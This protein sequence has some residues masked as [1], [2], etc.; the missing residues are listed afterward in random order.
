MKRTIRN[1]TYRS[2]PW[3]VAGLLCLALAIG[4]TVL[5]SIRTQ[6]IDD[7]GASLALTAQAIATELDLLMEERAGDFDLW[8]KTLAHQDLASPTTAAFLRHIR[9][10]YPIYAWIGVTDAT[11]RVLAAST[12]FDAPHGQYAPSQDTPSWF[13]VAQEHSELVIEPVQKA[14]ELGGRMALGFVMPLQDK[15]GAWRGALRGLIALDELAALFE[16][17]MKTFRLLG[18]SEVEVEWQW[19]TADGLVI[20]DSVLQEAGKVNLLQWH[21]PSAQKLQ[22]DHV[23]YL[24]ETHLRRNVPVI[25]GYAKTKGVQEKSAVQWG[26]LVRLDRDA[27]LK[28]IDAHLVRIGLVGGG[29][30]LPV[31]GV[32]MWS[33]TRAK[34]EWERVQAERVRAEQ[35]EAAAMRERQQIQAVVLSMREAVVTID[36][37][38]TITVVNPAA[39]GLFGYEADELVGRNVSMLMPSPHREHHDAYLRRYRETGERHIIG[40]GREV[41]GRRKDGSTFPLYLA[42]TEIAPEMGGGERQFTA[43]LRDLSQDK[44]IAALKDTENHVL[45]LL[46]LERPFREVLGTIA[47]SLHKTLPHIAVAILL[48]DE[49]ARCLRVGATAGVPLSYEK[50]LEGLPIAEDAPP[51]GIAALTGQVMDVRDIGTDPR[52]AAFREVALSHG[53]HACRSMPILDHNEQAVGV[54][55]V[56]PMTATW[57][58][59]LQWKWIDG[60]VRL[61]SLAVT[62]Y[63]TQERLDLAQRRYQTLIEDLDAV[64]WEADAQTWRFTYVSP[65][66]ERI[67]GYPLEQW[68]SE[69]EFWVHLIHPDDRERAVKTCRQAVAES[70]D[71]NFEYRTVAADGRIVWIRDIVHIAKDTDGQVAYLRGLFLD[72]TEIK[73]AEAEHRLATQRTALIVETALDAIVSMDGDGRITEWN[74]QAALL[75]GWQKEEVIGRDLAETIIPPAF[76][77]AHRK[78]VERFLETGESRV[79]NQRVESMA[80]DRTGREFPVEVTIGPPVMLEGV[81]SFTAFFRDLT[82]VK[83]LEQAEAVSHQV[84]YVLAQSPGFQEAIAQILETICRALGWQ[85]GAFW[86]E[87]PDAG[88]LRCRYVWHDSTSDHLSNFLAATRETTFARGIGL[89][90]RIWSSGQPAWILDVTQDPNFPRA[91]RARQAGLHGAVGFPVLHGDELLGVMEFFSQ[92]RQ[93]PNPHVLRMFTTVGRQIGQFLRRKRSE[94]RLAKATEELKM[95]NQELVEARDQALEALRVKSEFLAVMSHEIRTPM[96]GVIGMTSLLLDTDLTPEQRDY[97]E[98]IRSS[99]EHLLSIINDILDFS[100]IEAGKLQLE[101]IGFDVRAMV[102][103]VVEL[104]APRAQEKNVELTALV[105]ANVPTV[106]HGDPGRLRQI[107]GNL[108]S[109]AVKF[110]QQGEVVVAVKAE[111]DMADGAVIRFDVVDTGIGISPEAKRRLFQAFSQADSSM[112]RKYGGTG[113]G[114]AICKQLVELMGGRIGVDSEPGKGSRFW[115]TVRLAKPNAD[116]RR[117]ELPRDDL[118]GVSVCFVDDNATSLTVLE[119]YA[120]A[121]NMHAV[122][123][124]SGKEA[125]AVLT[126][127]WERGAPFDLA[128]VDMQMPEMDGLTLAKQIKRDPRLAA[129]RLVLLTSLAFRGEAQLAREAGFDAYLTKPVKREHLYACLKQVM[130]GERRAKTSGGDG[131]VVEEPDFRASSKRELPAPSLITRHTLREMEQHRTSRIL[132]A[133]DNLVNQKV[134]IKMLQK[135]GYA[136][137]VVGN[138]REAVEAVKRGSYALVLM[139]CM[140]PEMDGYQATREIREWEQANDRSPKREREGPEAQDGGRET[141]TG[142]QGS[143]GEISGETTIPE[144]G[145]PASDEQPPA[146]RHGR[147]TPWSHIPIIA[148]TA[149][150]MQ[151]DREKC[152]AAGMDDFLSK[153]LKPNELE[154]TMKTW[155]ISTASDSPELHRPSTEMETDE[156]VPFLETT[157][158]EAPASPIVSASTPSVA[159]VSGSPLDPGK[160]EELRALGG[161]EDPDFFALLVEQFLSDALG[162]VDAIRDAVAQRDASTLYKAAHTLKGS[163]RN[164]GATVLADVCYRFEQ[165]G[166]EDSWSGSQ[167]LMHRLTEEFARAETALRAEIAQVS[168]AQ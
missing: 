28:P 67:F 90:G 9:E 38:G 88:V 74:P 111:A 129:T 153:P 70:R 126:A 144:D 1:Y 57:P 155:I 7:V 24:E 65:Q 52:C 93:D 134:T 87:D 112:T 66:A 20:A 46:V 45:E 164:I 120:R 14:P 6:M 3:L 147:G 152:L 125:L 135:L 32:L 71:H 41:E 40:L 94:E 17:K 73:A 77:D 167:D 18:S 19:L 84:S 48:S 63:H 106:L 82:T 161:D 138:G 127:A 154:N 4:T 119:H 150:A 83:A 96:N 39:C 160:I 49:S 75:F 141:G 132:L 26:I 133:E 37:R 58:D 34:K 156:A 117:H 140:M 50:A 21:L 8:S 78:G 114:L 91:S 42:V 136:V 25:T 124:S 61:T 100:K 59:T 122:S 55:T 159:E 11:G 10:A 23:G 54:F 72:V 27:V 79:L 157:N 15:T 165:M 62:R 95:A 104:V 130:G 97:A 131:H 149:N 16:E 102:D 81:P 80:L 35:A 148:L 43:V 162:H 53:L 85:M 12:A 2:V 166:R 92:E 128:V 36:E 69:P 108:L 145:R 105:D 13:K 68:M 110:T 31:F 33:L 143:R 101:S 163:A 158:E 115:F 123:A 99:G 64:V 44:L 29:G 107:L 121:W 109:N 76:R 142:K 103:E 98:T 56:Y 86:V 22:T 60:A 47:E 168:R 151:G 51:C 146:S 139:D 137:D 5:W 118:R 89:P 113:L 116:I 30:G